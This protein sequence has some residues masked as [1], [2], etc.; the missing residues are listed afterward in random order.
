M[1]QGTMPILLI[2]VTAML[3][4]QTITTVVKV[5][6]PALFPAIADDLAFDAK[7]VLVYTWIIAV[8]S[9][10]VQAGCGGVIRRFGALRTSQIGCVFM[11]AGLICAAVLARVKQ[12]DGQQE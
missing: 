7:Y 2:A 1:M 3:I 12:P 9:I 5:G 8:G 4:Q 11:A 10:G 6:V